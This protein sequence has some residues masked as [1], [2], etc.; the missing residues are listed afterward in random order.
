MNGNRAKKQGF[1]LVELLL[2]LAICLA[3]FSIAIP[4]F[5]RRFALHRNMD[6]ATSKV[7]ETLLTARSNAVRD[8]TPYIF[9]YQKGSEIFT[10]R[11]IDDAASL[12]SFRLPSNIRF[13]SSR[14]GTRSD[15]KI[16][17]REDGSCQG[18]VFEL[19][20]PTESRR[21]QIDR[22]QGIPQVIETAGVK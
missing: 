2:A 4:P 1:T 8:S 18:A 19:S 10:I 20:G 9:E 17:Y 22:C 12:V 16:I 7:F 6:M 21:I 15:T 11:R 14:V 13:R 3:L 5:Y